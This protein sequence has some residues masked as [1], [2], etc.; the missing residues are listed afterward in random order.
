MGRVLLQTLEHVSWQNSFLLKG[1][2][3]EEVQ[4]LSRFTVKS[5]LSVLC[6]I[7]TGEFRRFEEITVFCTTISLKKAGF[8]R[9]RQ[10]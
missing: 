9:F 5:V 10:K 3:L 4:Q 2:V 8:R 1:P 6:A 7:K